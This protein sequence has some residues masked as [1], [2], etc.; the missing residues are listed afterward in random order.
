MMNV[1]DYIKNY[2]KV[3]GI[4]NYNLKSRYITKTDTATRMQFSGGVAFFYRLIAEGEITDINN[5]GKKFLEVDTP[6][7]YWD[8]SPVVEI[9]HFT[10]L[11][12]NT[13]LQIQK[14]C[15][16]FIFTADNTLDFKLYEGTADA[17]FANITNLCAQYIYL[18]PL[19]T[20][21]A[22]TTAPKSTSDD[23]ELFVKVRVN[24]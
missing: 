2:A 8:L 18:S 7:D 12:L 24:Q 20:E 21:A 3:H 15:T 23:E 16:D 1:F 9:V 13:R 6:T 5:L 4:S 10:V 14:V 19:P 11:N 22:T 17:M